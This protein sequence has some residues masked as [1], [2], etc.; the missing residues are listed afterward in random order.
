MTITRDYY[1]VLS[2]ERTADGSE[3]K[4]AYRRLAMKYHPDRNPGDPEAERLF[5]EAAEA[6]EVLSSTERRRIYDQYGHEG[7]RSRPGHDFRSMH[8]EDIFSMFEDIL[9]GFGG[10]TGR[11]RPQQKRGYDLETEVTV[12][13]MEVLT[14]TECDVEIDRQDVCDT[15]GGTGARPGTSPETCTTC[16]GNGQVQQAGLG[17]MFRMVSACPTC[18]GRGTVVTERCDDCRGHGRATV[19][20]SLL[21]RIP[22]GIADGQAIRVTGEGEPPPPEVSPDGSGTPG[23]LHV[24]IRV[25]PDDRFE[26][27]GDNLIVVEPVAF[28]QLAIGATVT[29]DTLDGT[30][31]LEIPA[32]TQ[33]N[34]LF[35]IASAGLPNLRSGK[36]GD[37]V[38]IVRLVVPR[39]LTERQKTLLSEY[40]ETEDTPVNEANGSFWEKIKDV[41]TGGGSQS[42]KEK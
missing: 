32:G 36:R 20:R 7:L 23:D 33:T 13:M 15:C 29:I 31:E 22:A 35:R 9:G 10:R 30:H 26:R 40:A 42:D 38:V 4:R 21:V 24:V 18:R 5:K 28:T 2:I 1:E 6:Y 16:N 39:K 12:S 34:E 19:H 27:D 25:Q 8:V 37:M 14:G 17:G 41:V 3:V 11:G